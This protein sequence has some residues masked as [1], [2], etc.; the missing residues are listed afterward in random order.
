MAVAIRQLSGNDAA[1]W[2]DLL[3]AS[4]GAD[5][6]DKNVYQLDWLA[7][8]LEPSSG[9]ETWSAEVNGR[10]HASVSFLQPASKIKDPV[11]N[12]G[13]QLFLPDSF[14]DGSAEGLL[15]HITHLGAERR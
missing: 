7:P 13:R 2:L 6:P 4:L 3:K 11:L 5:Y 12:L 14:Q 8:Q 9:Q 1:R 15:R 10:L